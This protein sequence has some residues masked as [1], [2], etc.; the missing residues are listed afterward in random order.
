MGKR[1]GSVTYQSGELCA[2]L[3]VCVVMCSLHSVCV[4][5]AVAS[6]QGELCGRNSI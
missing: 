4:N 1:G 2:R 6:G 3:L 5:C